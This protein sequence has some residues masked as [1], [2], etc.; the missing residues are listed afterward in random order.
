MFAFS[1][2]QV[3]TNNISKN[4]AATTIGIFVRK[5]AGALSLT[6]EDDGKGFDR[7]HANGGIGLANIR[8][9]VEGFNGTLTITTQLKELWR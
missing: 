1:T 5:N 7:E 9:G 4:T 8:N 6:I 3:Q 2:N